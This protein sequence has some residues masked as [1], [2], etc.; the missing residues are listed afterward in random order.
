[1]NALCSSFSVCDCLRKEQALTDNVSK[2]LSIRAQI[3][4]VAPVPCSISLSLSL[5]I[6]IYIYTLFIYSIYTVK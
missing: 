4:L 3:T 2:I 6:Y 1:M 5:Y